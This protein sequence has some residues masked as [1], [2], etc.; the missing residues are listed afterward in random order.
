[1][2]SAVLRSLFGCFCRR[3]YDVPK[4]TRVLVRDLTISKTGASISCERR[5]SGETF[6]LLCIEQETYDRALLSLQQYLHAELPLCIKYVET[7]DGQTKVLTDVQE[8]IPQD[9]V[10]DSGEPCAVPLST[11]LDRNLHFTYSF[12]YG[13]VYW[14]V[15]LRTGQHGN[16]FP[17]DER[18]LQVVG[19]D[20]LDLLLQRHLQETP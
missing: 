20:L 13:E 3:H 19:Y 1:M 4:E 11:V 10:D 17:V 18:L 15:V 2:L 12:E 16:R 5:N 14:I 9:G 8:F 7:R 6:L